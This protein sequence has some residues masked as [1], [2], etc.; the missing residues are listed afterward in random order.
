MKEQGWEVDKWSALIQDKEFVGWLLKVPSE[1]EQT[2]ARQVTSS[3]IRALEDL[4]RENPNATMED[5]QRDTQHDDGPNPVQV[6][7][8]ILMPKVKFG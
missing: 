3:Q 2:R 8:N 4:W 1:K 7:N 6:H 5:V